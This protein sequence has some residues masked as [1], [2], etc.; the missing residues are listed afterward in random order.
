[1]YRGGKVPDPIKLVRRL[2]A[3][4]VALGNLKRDCDIIAEKRTMVVKKV[5]QTQEENLL[6]VEEVSNT[7]PPSAGHEKS[8]LSFVTP[9]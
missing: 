9:R 3:L 1:M 8:L 6:K 4:E 7:P 5:L 2:T